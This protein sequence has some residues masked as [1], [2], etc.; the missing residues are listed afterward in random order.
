MNSPLPQAVMTSLGI[1]DQFQS[2]EPAAALLIIE[3]GLEQ[4][5]TPKVRP[6]CFSN[7]NL[8]ISALPQQKVGNAEF[9]AGTHQ[10]IELGQVAGVQFAGDSIFSQLVRRLPFR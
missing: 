3:H 2:T 7:V 5:Y 4:V 8:G 1:D 6:Q 10:Q 9:T